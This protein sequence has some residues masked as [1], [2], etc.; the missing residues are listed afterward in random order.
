MAL[1]HVPDLQL[2]C[3]FRPIKDI[4]QGERLCLT[5]LIVDINGIGAWVNV[6]AILD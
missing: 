2:I 5:V 1:N 4:L 6:R 3:N